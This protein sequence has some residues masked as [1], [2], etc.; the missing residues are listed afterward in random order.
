MK[1][2]ESISRTYVFA[3]S[4]EAMGF[5]TRVAVASEVAD[6]HPDIDTRWNKGT[7]VLSTHSEKAITSKELD[8][9]TAFNSFDR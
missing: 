1:T 2:G 7:I 9:A 8:L 4:K 6:H 5:L 3:D